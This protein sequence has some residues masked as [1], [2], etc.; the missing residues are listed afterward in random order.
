[1]LEEKLIDDLIE[2]GWYVLDTNFDETAFRNW[3]ER[4]LYCLAGLL[5]QDHHYT[6]SFRSWV[7]GDEKNN[8]LTGGGIL[9]A[10]KEEILKSHKTGNLDVNSSASVSV[11]K[12]EM[13]GIEERLQK[14]ARS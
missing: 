11:V 3:R 4:A 10:V 6:E 1:M 14:L 2:A 13:A 9:S 8:V 7:Q 5:G 12:D